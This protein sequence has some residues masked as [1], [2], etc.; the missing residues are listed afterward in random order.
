MALILI[1]TMIITIFLLDHY[2]M[3][4]DSVDHSVALV[5]HSEDHMDQDSEELT[6]VA[7]G[8]HTVDLVEDAAVLVDH[9]VD[10]VSATITCAESTYI[11]T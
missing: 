11:H 2:H 8:D 5:V 3:E 6:R 7:L 1:A 4:E 9:T 10:M